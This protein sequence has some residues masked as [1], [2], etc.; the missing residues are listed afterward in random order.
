[1]HM[2]ENELRS[3]NTPPLLPWRHK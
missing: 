1:M 2:H 3:G